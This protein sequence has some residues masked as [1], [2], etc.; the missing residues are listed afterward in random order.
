MG[1][2]PYHILLPHFILFR[3]GQ[4]I[5]S[6]SNLIHPVIVNINGF[7]TGNFEIQK[8][9]RQSFDKLHLIRYFLK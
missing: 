8:N 9:E 4:V 3:H 7:K 1:L 2:S 6:F 5:Q